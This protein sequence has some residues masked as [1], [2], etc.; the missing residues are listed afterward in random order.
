[1]TSKR[2]FQCVE[3]RSLSEGWAREA[4]AKKGRGVGMEFV[5]CGSSRVLRLPSSQGRQRGARVAA[6][7]IGFRCFVCHA[8]RL[9][10]MHGARVREHREEELFMQRPVLLGTNSQAKHVAP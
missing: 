6:S 10:I 9:Q 2:V 1:M 4:Q 8:R 7:C 5:V 3:D